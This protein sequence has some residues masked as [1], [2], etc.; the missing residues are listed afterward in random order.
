MLLVNEQKHFVYDK[1][2][3]VMILAQNWPKMAKSSWQCPF[4]SDGSIIKKS[5]VIRFNSWFFIGV[6]RFRYFFTKA[7]NKSDLANQFTFRHHSFHFQKQF[8]ALFFLLLSLECQIPNNTSLGE[9]TFHCVGVYIFQCSLSYSW[10]LTR[11][12]CKISPDKVIISK[13]L[14]KFR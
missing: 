13:F 7:R 2:L 10:E 14:N 6:H 9:G 4:N 3:K 12:G 1:N 5:I 8:Y 11:C